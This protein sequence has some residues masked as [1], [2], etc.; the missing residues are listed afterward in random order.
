MSGL[1]SQPRAADRRPLAPGDVGANEPTEIWNPSLAA[2]EVPSQPLHRRYGIQVLRTVTPLVLA[3]WCAMAVAFVVTH[4]AAGWLLDRPINHALLF[5][6]T[7]V[8]LQF[9]VF[10]A[11]GLYPGVGVHPAVELRQLTL[12]WAG[13]AIVSVAFAI[14]H[15]SA[16]SPYAL[17]AAGTFLGSLLGSPITRTL[18]R[19]W[20]SQYNWW[21]YPV[22]MIG[23]GKLAD[24]ID[25]IFRCGGGRGLRLLGRFDHT[26]RYW[27]EPH[28]SRLAWLGNLEDVIRYA[29]Q[30]GVFWLVIAMPD[31]MDSQ[32]VTWVQFFRQRF[33]HVVLIHTRHELPSL[34]H[35]PLDCGG[36]SAVQV[37]ERLMMPEQ[38]LFKRALDLTLVL[39]GGLLLLPLM[40]V[41]AGLV[42]LSSGRPIFYRNPRVGREGHRFGAWKFRTMVPHADQVLDA[43]LAAHPQARQE[44]EE[45]HKLKQDPRITRI[46]S[47]LRKTSLDELPQIWN[48]LRGEMSVVGPRPIQVAE[49]VK[50]GETYDHYLR[51]RPGITGMWQISGRNN[52]TYQERLMHDRFYVRNWSPWLDLYILGRTLKTVLKCE[53]AY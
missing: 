6:L 28:D 50:Y 48:V 9:I 42:W 17:L 15:S 40:L 18:V 34:W 8:C 51:V 4:Q 49:I 21:G 11:S 44:Y 29:K 10:F 45:N 43:Y 1:K 3:D 32:M 20:A 5:L 14:F 35:R 52:T 12:T 2:D 36:L 13:L 16:Q 23:E 19:S 27:Q 26:H 7:A 46:G 37:E 33:R 47:F 41:L 22:I 30:N 31:R 39:V 53:G 24:Q 25:D 38:Q